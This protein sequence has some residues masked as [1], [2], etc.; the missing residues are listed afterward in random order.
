MRS[1]EALLRRILQN[2]VSNAIRY[3]RQGRIVM[4]CRRDGE[5][6]R[7]EVHD[8]APAFRPVCKKRFLKSSAA[9][10]KAMPT[11]APG[12]GWR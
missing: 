5:H 2:F 11:A 6:V 10:T 8:Q 4:G 12:W 3:S 1:D 9:W 7:I